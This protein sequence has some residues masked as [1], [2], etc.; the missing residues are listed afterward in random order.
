MGFNDGMD[1]YNH[2]QSTRPFDIFGVSLGRTPQ[3]FHDP[4][5]DLGVLP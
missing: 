1:I 5:A 2:F 3:F 4:L